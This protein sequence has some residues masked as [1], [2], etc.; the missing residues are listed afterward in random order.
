MPVTVSVALVGEGVE[1]GA[2]LVVLL[3]PP[4]HPTTPQIRNTTNAASTRYLDRFLTPTRRPPKTAAKVNGS[5]FRSRGA[6]CACCVVATV[7]VTFAEDAVLVKLTD[8]GF[9]L[10]VVPAGAPVHVMAT[11]PVNPLLPVPSVRLY[12]AACPAATVAEL[13]EPENANGCPT[14]TLVVLLVL[15]PRLSVTV[16]VTV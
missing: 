7:T 10:Q 6:E 16:A 9:A 14:F 12:V 1:D 5:P 2:E 8:P 15:S 13:L 11:V 3:D 4:A